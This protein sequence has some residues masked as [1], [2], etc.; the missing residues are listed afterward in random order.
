MK[1]LWIL[2][3]AVL[4]LCL[5]L[6]A[7]RTSSKPD[8]PTTDG[9]EVTTT[10]VPTDGGTSG[11]EEKSDQSTAKTKVDLIL[12]AGDVNM[13][14][15]G[16]AA[17]ATPVA[18]G[19][20]YEFRAV[21]DP[22]KLYALDGSF[23]AAEQKSGGLSDSAKRASQ[24]SLVP[25]F[26]EAYYQRTGTPVVAVSASE[27]GATIANW[28]P[29]NGKVEDAIARMEAAKAYID[30]SGTYEVGHILLVWCQGESDAAAGT[31]RST[32]VTRSTT[33]LRA[34]M[35]RGVE[36]CMVI[37][38]G[39]VPGVDDEANASLHEA[40][41]ELCGKDK[42][43]VLISVLF[44]QESERM[45]GGAYTQTAY[46][47][48]GAD[49]GTNAGIYLENPATYK[50]PEPPKEPVEAVEEDQFGGNPIDLPRDEW[51]H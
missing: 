39:D 48:V 24:G 36:T 10:E 49:A 8:T 3:A 2:L 13:S 29:S 43:F 26:C 18:E 32:Y 4:A 15:R 12:F 1:K 35:R 50:E 31:D 11:G 38:S 19:H 7:C 44:G 47:E 14:G 28:L 23:G 17:E 33:V 37:Q 21:S 30:A 25:A 16:T 22:T 46:N 20:A 40:Q 34:L 27:G 6:T 9:T 41:K 42:A 45:E 51:N 5:A